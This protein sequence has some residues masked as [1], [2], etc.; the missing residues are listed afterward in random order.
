MEHFESYYH[1]LF[2]PKV[3]SALPNAN[4]LVCIYVD[5]IHFKATICDSFTI[6]PH[7][8]LVFQF[9]ENGLLFE[10][11]KHLRSMLLGFA[12]YKLTF[13][14]QHKDRRATQRS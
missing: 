9:L 8:S 4:V 5:T 12:V 7:I 6:H 11:S 13:C 3:N 1:N 14:K 2:S 10:Q